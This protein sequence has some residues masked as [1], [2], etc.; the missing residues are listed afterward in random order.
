MFFEL[1]ICTLSWVLATEICPLEIRTIG[2]GFH[3]APAL[4]WS[5]R[6]ASLGWR[7]PSWPTLLPPPFPLQSWET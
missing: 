4:G 5:A 7:L 2:A 3:G 1:S 6:A